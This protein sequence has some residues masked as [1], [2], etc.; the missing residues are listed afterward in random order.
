VALTSKRV[1]VAGR[2]PWGE[3]AIVSLSYRRLI[4]VALPVAPDALAPADCFA[5]AAR[6]QCTRVKGQPRGLTLQAQ[7]EHE[8][9]QAARRRQA[10]DAFAVLYARRAGIEGTISQGVRAFGLRR[11]RSRGLP[12]THLQHLV[13]GALPRQRSGGDLLHQVQL[14]EVQQ[15]DPPLPG[16]LP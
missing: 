11:A 15:V 9:V 5:C 16:G 8:A 6:A 12:K 2:A 7:A 4:S 10:T 13:E 14:Q 3:P 1:A